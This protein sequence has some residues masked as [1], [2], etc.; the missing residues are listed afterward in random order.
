LFQLGR[1][2]ILQKAI[3]YIC[4]IKNEN[5]K[6]KQELRKLKLSAEQELQ[7]LKLSVEERLKELSG[8]VSTAENSFRNDKTLFTP[9]FDNL[10]NSIHTLMS[11]VATNNG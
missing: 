3:D 11:I 5:E 1:P 2:A 7:K 10:R 6:L 8:L 4:N 9:F